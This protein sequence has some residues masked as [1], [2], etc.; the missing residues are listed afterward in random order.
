[1]TLRAQ[2]ETLG[3]VFVFALITLTVGT[4]YALGVPAL[5]GAQ[6]DERD[7]N[8]ERAFEVLD[9]NIED[10]ARNGAPSRATEIKLAGGSISIVGETTVSV[11][12]TDT[13]DSSINDTFSMTTRRISYNSG[14][15]TTVSYSNGAIIRSDD[16]NA[17]MRSDPNWIVDDDRTVIPLI[18]VFG[19]SERD[20]LGGET[21]ILILTDR[22]SQG[23]AGQFDTGNEAEVNV[24]VE[25]SNAAAWA[26]FLEREGMDPVDA[27]PTDGNVTYQFR[28]DTLHV[29]RTSLGTTLSE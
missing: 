10:V 11:S 22:S 24:T 26:A 9:D 19:E 12:V 23:L 21:T 28:T 16:G 1:V 2:S 15:G 14:D 5:Q 13:T 4:V 18:V 25:S 7:N 6:A 17:V 20:S 29:S 3:F 8:M 27:D